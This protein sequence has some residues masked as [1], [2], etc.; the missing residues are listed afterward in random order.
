[1]LRTLVT[2]TALAVFASCAPAQDFDFSGMTSAQKAAFGDAVRDYLMENPEVL[3]KAADEAKARQRARNDKALI[4]ANARDLFEDGHSWIGGNPDGD[5]TI[6]EFTDYKCS[7]C[8]KAHL[9]I[10]DLLRNDDNIRLIVKEFPILGPQS[11]LGARFALA[12]QQIDG[13]D[14]YGKIH[15]ALMTMRG[16]I[17]VERL[18]ALTR[19]EGLDPAPLIERMNADEVSDILRANHELAQRMGIRGAPAFVIGDEM[20]HRGY[21][22][23]GKMAEM[24]DQARKDG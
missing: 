5:I 1:M 14:T 2:A 8:R 10:A 3:L 6:V 7:H 12:V 4:Q 11:D 24:V 23:E 16:D 19:A 17:S 22:P 13:Q 18:T 15:D 9:E 20:L 21:D